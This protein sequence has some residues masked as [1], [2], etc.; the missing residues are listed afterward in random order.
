MKSFLYAGRPYDYNFDFITDNQLVCSELIYKSY[1]ADADQQGLDLPLRSVA[2]RILMP[3]NEIA[4]LYSE[5]FGTAQ[6]Q[7]DLV[8]FLDGDE[9]AKRAIEATDAT[10]RESWTR[11]KW[12]IIVTKADSET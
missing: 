8:L 2:G 11:P 9:Y 3:A 4:Q 7:M 1:Q 5:N 10:F 6:Q 12:H